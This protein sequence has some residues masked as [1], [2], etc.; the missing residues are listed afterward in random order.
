MVAGIKL[1]NGTWA[2]FAAERMP[3]E[4]DDAIKGTQAAYYMAQTD[5]TPAQL[6]GIIPM[7]SPSTHTLPEFP[8]IATHKV[9]EWETL[10]APYVSVECLIRG[11]G[12]P[13]RPGCPPENTSRG[14]PVA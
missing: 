5:L 2:T 6:L 1:T 11:Q 7:A 14:F 8:G 13:R 3:Q 4:L 10:G 12:H 9:D